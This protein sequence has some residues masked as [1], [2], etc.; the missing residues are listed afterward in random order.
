[1]KIVHGASIVIVDSW[2]FKLFMLKLM[3]TEKVTLFVWVV[4]RFAK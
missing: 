1:M 4:Y 3:G 2:M